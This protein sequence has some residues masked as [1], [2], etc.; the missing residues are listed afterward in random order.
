MPSGLAL[1]VL[2]LTDW[3]PTPLTVMVAVCVFC[4]FHATTGNVIV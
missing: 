4:T 3:V 1:S 2:W